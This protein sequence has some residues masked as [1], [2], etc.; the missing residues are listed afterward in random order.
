MVIRSR[1][2]E[3]HGKGMRNE[4]AILGRDRERRGWVWELKDTSSDTRKGTFEVDA[5]G[6]SR[7]CTIR[8]LNNW[9]CNKI[10]KF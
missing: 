6:L 7:T 10:Y 3:S 5:E 9:S 2:G 1:M 8:T 4:D